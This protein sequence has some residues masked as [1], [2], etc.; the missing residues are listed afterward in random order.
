MCM[1]VCVRVQDGSGAIDRYEL[2]AALTGTVRQPQCSCYQQLLVLT[3]PLIA[4]GREPG[5]ETEMDSIM[6]SIDEDG[7]GLIG[8]C[9]ELL[10]L[11]PWLT[12]VTRRFLRVL[13]AGGWHTSV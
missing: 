10:A 7:S 13:P 9:V 8:V 6:E 12:V 1:C 2:H 3:V 5:S 4:L 11:R